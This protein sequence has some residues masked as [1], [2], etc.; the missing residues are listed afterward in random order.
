MKKF[1]KSPLLI[2]TL[3]LTLCLVGCNSLG[4]S[5]SQGGDSRPNSSSPV[6]T[7]PKDMFIKARR[8]TVGSNSKGFEYNYKTEVSASVGLLGAEAAAITGKTEGTTKYSTTGEVS[9]YDEHVN[10]GALFYDGTKYQIRKG[11]SLQNISFNEDGVLNKYNVEEVDDS[12]KYDTSSFAKALFEYSDEEI[13]NVT[14]G[15]GNS[16]NISTKTNM[17]KVI[18][19]L[20]NILASPIVKHTINTHIDDVKT[21]M[22]VTF[23]SNNNYLRSYTYGVEIDVAMVLTFSLKY[24]LDFTKTNATQVITP[25]KFENI[26]ITSEDQ[27]THKTSISNALSAYYAKEHSS[28]DFEVNTGVNFE[29][30]LEINSKFKGETKRKVDSENNKVYFLN[31]IEID[32]DY[33]NDDVYKNLEVDDIHV[34]RTRLSNDEVWNIEKKVLL[35]KT[36]KIDSYVDNQMDNFYL[37]QGLYE[38]FSDFP[39]IQTETDKNNAVHY[40]LGVSTQSIKGLLTYFN[41]ELDLDPMYKIEKDLKVFGDFK[42]DTIVLNEASFDITLSGNAL[43]AVTLEV[44]GEYQTK[45]DGSKDFYTNGRADFSIDY[46]LT[47]TSKGDQFEPFTEVKDAK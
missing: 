9:F 31:D 26:A 40:Y 29:N 13:T 8:N 37:L 39:F 5:S 42:D 11:K 35:D 24:T 14:K 28:Y 32:S 34:R 33:K 1:N 47:T 15:S 2:S 16:Y 3:L 4:N 7:T 17:T 6:V 25:K 36:E 38:L 45:L 30:S 18:N 44:Q 43:S 10:S 12:Y 21:T 22:A 19:V 41:T 20:G 27:G 23:S 46:S